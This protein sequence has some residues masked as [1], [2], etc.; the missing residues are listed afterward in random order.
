[1]KDKEGYASKPAIAVST[2]PGSKF[3]NDE[4]MTICT[5]NI[6]AISI[7]GASIE[8]PGIRLFTDRDTL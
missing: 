8:M 5:H 7:H 1:M 2:L 3:L 4:P 6:R